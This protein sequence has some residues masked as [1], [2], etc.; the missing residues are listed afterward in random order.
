MGS[1]KHSDMFSLV[2]PF[3][4]QELAYM[5]ASVEDIYDSFVGLVAASRNMTVPD[6]DAIAQGR[7]WSGDDAL[8]IGLV[9]AIGTLEDAVAY[10]AALADYHSSDE[11]TVC[12]YPEPLTMF[13]QLMMQFGSATDEPSILTGTPFEALGP[14]VASLKANQPGVIYARLPFAMDIR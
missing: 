4:K 1:N 9:D 6:V 8:K 14:A 5:Q 7:V 10:A 12:D 13:Q 3:D 2:R 11:Y